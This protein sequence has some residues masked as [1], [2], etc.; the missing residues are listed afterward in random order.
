M[1]L[2]LPGG[3]LAA[4]GHLVIVDGD[5]QPSVPSSRPRSGGPSAGPHTLTGGA[6]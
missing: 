2:A 1:N 5:K 3:A 6:C 4:K